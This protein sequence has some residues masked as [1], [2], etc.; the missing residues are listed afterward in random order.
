MKGML[1]RKATATA[2]MKVSDNLLQGR[3]NKRMSSDRIRG[4][5]H[6]A[7]IVDAITR[8]VVSGGG[9]TP[10]PTRFRDYRR[11]GDLA[12]ECKRG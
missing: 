6:V 12:D 4:L 1:E 5:I 10:L 2:L 9:G 8:V 3:Q 7:G 11:S